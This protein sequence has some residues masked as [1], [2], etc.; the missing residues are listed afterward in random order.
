MFEYRVTQLLA[1]GNISHLNDRINGLVQEGW[2]PVMMCGDVNLSVLLRRQRQA[3]E[4][5]HA[6]QARH[7][8]LMTD[9]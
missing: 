3:G 4:H 5:A 1:G 7:P 2:E 8:A 9:E 6:A